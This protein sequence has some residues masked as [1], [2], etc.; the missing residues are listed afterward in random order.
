VQLHDHDS[1]DDLPAA[2]VHVSVPTCRGEPVP[3][4]PGLMLLTGTLSV[5]HQ[6]ETDGRLSIVRLALDPPAQEPKRE[7][8][9]FSRSRAPVHSSHAAAKTDFTA[10]QH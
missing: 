4:A 1:S 8:R 2:L 3:Y 6:E 7:R 5:G 10:H 9:W